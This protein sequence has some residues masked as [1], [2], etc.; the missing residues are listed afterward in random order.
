MNMRIGM[1]RV[2]GDKLLSCVSIREQDQHSLAAGMPPYTPG[3]SVIT[4]IRGGL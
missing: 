2:G 4:L 3:D 1:F